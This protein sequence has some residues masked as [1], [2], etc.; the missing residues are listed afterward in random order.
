MLDANDINIEFVG[1]D[2][3]PHLILVR[4]L[5]GSGKST[6]ACNI[7]AEMARVHG[8][9][10]THL[11]TD[12]FF[13]DKKHGYVFHREQLREAHEWC[14]LTAIRLLNSHQRVIVSNTFSQMWE[15]APYIDHVKYLGYNF[16]VIQCTGDYGSIHAVPKTA[17]DN[18]RE[19]WEVFKR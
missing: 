15:M 11:E 10:Y 12:F 19:R 18:M 1:P 13:V 3:F 2:M 9:T 7:Q 17:I 8:K 4:G 16:H 5:P 6:R 14:V